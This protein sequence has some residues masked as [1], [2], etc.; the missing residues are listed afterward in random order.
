MSSL[1]S[2]NPVRRLPHQGAVSTLHNL[3]HRLESGDK[4]DLHTSHSEGSEDRL[5]GASRTV[6]RMRDAVRVPSVPC[7]RA[8]DGR[9]HDMRGAPPRRCGGHRCDLR[10]PGG[11]VPRRGHG[12]PASDDPR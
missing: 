8:D 2:R 7:R 12:G 10:G 4:H 1:S 3:G 5:R 6:R 9:V 11:G